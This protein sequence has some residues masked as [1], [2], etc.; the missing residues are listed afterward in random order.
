[1]KAEAGFEL[2]GRVSLARARPV[3]QPQK[4]AVMKDLKIMKKTLE[5]FFMAFM[6]FTFFMF[7][8]L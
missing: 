8:L 7:A 2:G 4:P 3:P 1:M 5:L 6:L